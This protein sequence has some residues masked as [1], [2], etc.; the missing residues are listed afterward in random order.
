MA[1]QSLSVKEVCMFTRRISIILLFFIS[2]VI[3]SNDFIYLQTRTRENI[4]F[5][6]KF[7][8]GDITGA[9]K[10]EFKDSDWRVVDL[11][12]DWSIEGPFSKDNPTGGGGGYLPAGI[13]WYRKHFILPESWKEKKIYIQ[14]DGVYMNCDVWINGKHL[15]IHPYGYTSFYYDLTPYLNFGEKENVLVVKVDNSK[16]PNSRWYSGSG[17]YRHV[18]L[19]T[20]DKLHIGH[21]GTYVT[22]SMV[23]SEF[24]DVRL[25]VWVENEKKTQEEFTLISII[26]DRE[27]KK[28][29]TIKS[30]EQIS[31][32]GKQELIQNFIIENPTLWSTDNPYLYRIYTEINKEGIIVDD[33]ITTLGIRDIRFDVDRG[34]FLNGQHLKVNGACIHHDGG[35]LGAA[36]PERVWERRLLTLKEMGCNALRISHNPPSPELLDLCDKMGFLVMDEAFDEWKIGKR[37]HGYH[38]YFDEWA[39]E[40]LKSMLLRDRN[41]PS[42]FMWSVGNEI[43]EQTHP[44]GSDILKKLVDVCHNEDPTR[45]VT[46]GCDNIAAEPE[47][48]YVDFLKIL[49]V[50]GYNYVDRWGRRRELYYDSDR[51]RFPSRKIIGSES[52]PIGWVVRGFYD[53]EAVNEQGYSYLTRTIRVEQLWKFVKVHDYVIGDFMWTG[54]DYLGEAFWPGKNASSGQIDLCGFPKDGYYFYKSQWTKEPMIYLFPHWNWKGN[55][56]KIIPVVCYTNCESV[57]LLLNDKS[58]GVKRV[59]FPRQ[60]T[61]G[62]WNKYANPRIFPTTADLHLSWDIPYEPGVLKAIGKRAGKVVC[63][64]EILTSKEPFKIALIPDRYTILANG[65]D[66]VH[67][68]IQILD[69]DGIFVPT[70]DDLINFKV[71]GE[72]EIIGVGNGNPF[73]HEDFKAN[74][75][76]AFNGLCLVIVQSTLVP[77]EIQVE[78]SSPSLQSASI[79]LNTI[80][81]KVQRISIITTPTEIVADGKSTATLKA[82]IKDEYG[83]TIPRA[84]YPITFKIE[85]PVNFV[86]GEKIYKT[87]SMKGVSEAKV[88]ASNTPGV[89]TITAKSEG[90]VMGRTYI[91]LLSK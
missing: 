63:Q 36:V 38:E 83:V 34:F 17:I 3:S 52:T 6:W 37:A 48:T 20:T 55:E 43:P 76:K 46:S 49:D 8:K 33:Y 57:E 2:L 91:K 82:E 73:S 18:W 9:W 13:G 85:G 14:F 87:A 5:N 22:T 86:N 58:Y 1:S 30:T 47:S 42:V 72:G 56:G 70:S 35:C 31:G 7:F 59:E 44:E 74:N 45:P 15:G 28:V 19:I 89:V 50:V 66:V 80:S 11:P 21:W 32:K 77:G 67:L 64:Q 40:D 54:I 81:P 26:L 62:G 41:H 23:S 71:N 4:D 24:A 65:R 10:I 61:K 12:H 27:G 16:Q 39:I 84:D 51:H 78:A 68:T 53:I 29:K 90:K 60:G 75:R 88:I 69:K 25:R 79:S